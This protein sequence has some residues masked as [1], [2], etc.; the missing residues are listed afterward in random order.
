MTL[1]NETTLANAQAVLAVL[2]TELER[3]GF[4]DQ[5]DALKGVELFD[6]SGAEVALLTLRAL[7][8]TNEALD[9]SKGFLLDCLARAMAPYP[10]AC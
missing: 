6:S 7:P 10:M 8:E 1:V 2:R 5:A 9:E 3:G 4:R